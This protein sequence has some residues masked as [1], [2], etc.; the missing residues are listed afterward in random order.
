M[1]LFQFQ[2][3]PGD[4]FVGIEKYANWRFSRSDQTIYIGSPDGIP[5][6][7]LPIKIRGLNTYVLGTAVT[8]T[9][10]VQDIYMTIVQYGSIGRYWRY[11]YKNVVELVSKM[12]QEQTRTPLQELMMLSDRFD[13]LFESEKARLKPM[14]PAYIVPQFL[15]GGGMP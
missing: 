3:K 6:S 15:Q 5:T 11:R 13:R 9:I 7:G 2:W 4:I 12:T 8:S 10:D 1:Y 14:K